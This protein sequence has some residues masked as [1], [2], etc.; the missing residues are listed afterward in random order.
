ML[1]E[2]TFVPVGTQATV[3][4]LTPEELMELGVEI[5]FCNT[6]HLYL[7][8]GDKAIRK[9]GGLHKFTRWNGKIITDSGG[10]QVFSLGRDHNGAGKL[11][12][13]NE[14]GVEFKSHLD[15]STHI[16]T[17]ERSIQ[18]QHN[19]A[20]DYLIAFDECTPY[21]ATKKYAQS[22]LDRT[23]RWALRS[24][25]EHKKLNKKYNQDLKL[26][27]VIQGSYYKD[28]RQ[29]SAEFI[30]NN[31]FDGIAIGGVSVGEPKD[32]M[33]DAVA[34]VMPLINKDPKH[35][36]VHLLGVGEVDDLFDFFGQ[37]ITSMDCTLPTRMA[38]AG[39]FLNRTGNSTHDMRTSFRSQIMWAKF[40]TDQNPLDHNCTCHTCKNYDRAYLHHLFKAQELLGYRLMTYHN[41]HFMIHTTQLIRD[42][43]RNGTF[44]Q[45]KYSWLGRK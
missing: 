11:V 44:D 30:I 7:R 4:S 16:F 40:R 2:P 10:F 45:L 23:H 31:D 26:Y 13:I 17:P 19:L 39:Q 18:I 6:Y 27:G 8:P 24:L 34:Y 28:L 21:P 12:K 15:G 29:Q 41:I 36:P 43:L 20:A 25:K 38:R 14:D 22:A 32:K 42:A 33:R 9:F 5:F 35:R 1:K 3:K 37:R